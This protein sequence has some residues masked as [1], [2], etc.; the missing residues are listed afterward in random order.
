ME[1]QSRY[2]QLQEV[3]EELED[4]MGAVAKEMGTLE[5]AEEQVRSR[6]PW[7]AQLIRGWELADD[8]CHTGWDSRPE[9]ELQRLGD[10]INL[11]RSEATAL[12]ER[13]AKEEGLLA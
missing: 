3:R 7:V 1:M 5:R 6:Y 2:E 8:A 13:L 4:Q 10:L 11:L 9:G 12:A